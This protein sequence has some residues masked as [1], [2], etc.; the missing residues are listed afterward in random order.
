MDVPA[1]L[2]AL[3]PRLSPGATTATNARRLSGGASQ[4]TWAFDLDD[5]TP[6][7]LRRRP[8]GGDR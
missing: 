6:L 8:G 7:I 4:E 2:S 1:A 3:A 5:G